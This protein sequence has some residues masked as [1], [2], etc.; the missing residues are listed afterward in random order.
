[1]VKILTSLRYFFLIAF[2]LMGLGALSQPSWMWAED[3]F[4][5]GTERAHDVAM[6]P[7]TKEVV[8]AGEYNSSLAAFYGSSFSGSSKGGF[9]AKYSAAG[10]VLWGFKIGSNN[11]NICTGVEI[12]GAGNIYVAGKFKDPTDFRGLSATGTTVNPTGG[13][14]A[15]LAKYNSAGQLLWVKKVGGTGDDGGAAVSLSPGRVVLT[16]FYKSSANAGTLS[17]H[18]NQSGNNVFV[19]AYSEAGSELWLA[20]AGGT[21]DGEGLD[22]VSDNSGIYVSGKFRGSSLTFYNSSGTNGTTLNNP[23]GSTHDAFVLS[24]NG[25]GMISWVN[26]IRSSDEDQAHG[27][28]LLNSNLYVCGS[29]EAALTLPSYAS[30]PLAFGGGNR[31]PFVAQ[32]NKVSGV[33]N[34]ARS[35]ASSDVA[36][37]YSIAADGYDAIYFGGYYKSSLNFTGGANFSAGGGEDE[38]LFIACLGADG[39]YRWAYE[40][41]ENHPDIV[42]GVSCVSPNEVTI[43]GEY[44]Q[45]PVFGSYVLTDAGAPN[46]FAARLSCPPVSNN[47]ISSNQTICAG[48]APSAL[49]G[50]TVSGGTAPYSY[51]WEESDDALNW[52]AA[53]G[54]NATASYSPPV[55]SSQKFYRRKVMSAI[56][57]F[58]ISISN[59]VA[60]AVDQP[61]STAVAGTDQTVCISPGSANISAN[62]PSSGTGVWSFSAGSGS[63][64]SSGTSSTSVSGLAAGTNILSWTVSNGVCPASV[65]QLTIEVHSLPTTAAAGIDLSVCVTS[66]M[67][68]LSGN[69]PAVGTGSW[70]TSS[71]LLILTPTSNNSS[72][73]SFTP[74]DHTFTWTISNG[75]CPP[76]SDEMI[77]HIDSL[78]LLPD[79][80]LDQTICE[81]TSSVLLA[82]NDPGTGSGLWTVISGS[83]TVLDPFDENSAVSLSG[84]APVYLAWKISNNTCTGSSDTMKIIIDPLPSTAIAGPDQSVCISSATATLNASLPVVGTGAWTS[85]SSLAIADA[86]SSATTVSAFIPGNHSLVWTITSGVCAVS[87]DTM[88]LTIDSLPLPSYAGTDQTVCQSSPGIVLSGNDPV[89]ATGLWTVASGSAIITDASDPESAATVSGS[90]PVTLIW[91]VSNNTCI[92]NGDTMIVFIDLPPSEANAGSDQQY[93]ESQPFINLNAT[94]PAVGSGSWSSWSSTITVSDVNAAGSGI[95]GYVPGSYYFVWQTMNG[96]C[97]LSTDT[98]LIAVDSM[99]SPAVAGPDQH[100]CVSDPVTISALSPQTGNGTWSSIAG[101]G[102]PLFALSPVTTV[103][104][105]SAGNNVFVWTVSNGVCPPDSDTLIV[106]LDALPSEAFAGEDLQGCENASLFLQAETPSTGVGEWSIFAGSGTF[107]NAASATSE[108]LY[109][110]TGAHILTWSVSNGLCPSSTDTVQVMIVQLPTIANAGPDQ[111]VKVSYAEIEAAEV[112]IGSGSWSAVTAGAFITDPSNEETSVQGFAPGQNVFRWTV[113]NPGCPSS[114]DDVIITLEEPFI[115]NAFSPNND[116]INDTYVIPAAEYYNNVQLSIFNKWGNV[117]YSSGSYRND[118]NGTNDQGAPLTDDTYY[119]L[120]D[121]LPGLQYKGFIILKRN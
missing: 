98:V 20:D 13:F 78:P 22:V 112:V 36:E 99:P 41:G 14:D 24:L 121:L 80:G 27:I 58:N 120:L 77:L 57:C 5:S 6:D 37:A 48:T 65:D 23:A 43:A 117:V 4:T 63:I 54:I 79:A 64:A 11:D 34:W 7:V 66:G 71:P 33:T 30:N 101:T 95:S 17:S 100:Q 62:I 56:T 19:V 53:P 28:T 42:Y 47:V 85:G 86:T 72:V 8:I 1:M 61:P 110:E 18:A 67:I 82:A 32:I 10:A 70:S 109:S 118:W 105:A 51:L 50:T 106:I 114:T 84:P 115:P 97:P 93:C 2:L 49:T 31:R 12:D 68:N 52:S 107:Q 113:A 69:S 60:I 119:Y 29:Y 26:S 76:S 9:V 35:M 103:T 90:L 40:A 92:G 108:F 102:V 59:V 38:N 91:T 88:I 73:N 44:R 46:I 87:S 15:F 16:G 104:G 45:E 89:T 39:S 21:Q 111:S 55:I 94:V 81:S 25:A 96:V 116:G 3:A 83:A 75:V 74:G